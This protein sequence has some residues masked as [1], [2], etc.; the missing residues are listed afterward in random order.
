[1][2]PAAARH[3]W[4]AEARKPLVMF[5]RHLAR[6][7]PHHPPPRATPRFRVAAGVLSATPP[8]PTATGLRSPAVAIVSAR[9]SVRRPLRATRDPSLRGRRPHLPRLRLTASLRAKCLMNITRASPAPACQPDPEKNQ[10]AATPRSTRRPVS[11][12]YG[13]RL[14]CSLPP[15]IQWYPAPVAHKFAPSVIGGRSARAIRIPP[16]DYI[17][18]FPP[19][20]GAPAAPSHGISP[21]RP[22]HQAPHGLSE[23]P[24]LF[25]F[26]RVPISA[27]QC[28]R[29]HAPR[30]HNIA[31]SSSPG[32]ASQSSASGPH[33]PTRRP[34]HRPLTGA[35][36][37]VDLDILTCFL[38][39]LNSRNLERVWRYVQHLLWLQI[40]LEK[41]A[42]S[43]GN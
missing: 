18:A 3:C 43:R 30:R 25:P 42:K 39:C 23:L 13:S 41:T 34:P 37:P 15:L 5:I 16:L 10:K 11:C 21:R 26:A 19:P 6:P 36:G 29:S 17:P 4:Q 14:A 28:H 24:V 40:S 8:T 32:R 9:P 27:V 31:S 1:M 2:R 20:P 22:R 38:R 33:P 12:A 35:M 7:S